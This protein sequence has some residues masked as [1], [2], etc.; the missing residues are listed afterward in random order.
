VAP[1]VVMPLVLEQP[2]RVQ[3]GQRYWLNEDEWVLF[4]EEPSGEGAVVPVP[5]R[6]GP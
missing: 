2:L 3:Q 5:V 1:V 4:V 6:N